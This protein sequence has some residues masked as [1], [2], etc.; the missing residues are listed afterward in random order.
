MVATLSDVPAGA[1]VL[2]I[3]GAMVVG[4]CDNCGEYV[5]EKDPYFLA[6][7][8]SLICTHCMGRNLFNV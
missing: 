5:T 3:N 8:E 6:E 2:E 4:K 1:S 7:D